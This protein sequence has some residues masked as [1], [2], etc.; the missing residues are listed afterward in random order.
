[1]GHGATHVRLR[2]V[3]P[4]HGHLQR[5]RTPLVQRLQYREYLGTQFLKGG[6]TDL[7]RCESLPCP[8]Q[9]LVELGHGIAQHLGTIQV[10]DDVGSVG[11]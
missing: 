7:R 3:H 6:L 10:A 4:I 2:N 5:M 11:F 8:C 1:M 9:I